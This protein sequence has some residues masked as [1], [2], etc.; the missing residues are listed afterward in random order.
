MASGA[1]PGAKL[2]AWRVGEGVPGKAPRLD[3]CGETGVPISI[4]YS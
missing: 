3:S 1:G 2:Q 4:I